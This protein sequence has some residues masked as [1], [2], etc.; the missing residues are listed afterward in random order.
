MALR[1]A[2]LYDLHGNLPALEAVLREVDREQ[3]DKIVVGGDIAAGPFPRETV[4]L[5]RS[6]G[7]LCIRGNADWREGEWGAHQW[8]WDQ[9]DAE[10]ADWLRTLPGHAVLDGIF[11][12]HATPHS[13]IEIVTSATTHDRL[14]EVLAGVR[15]NVVVAGHTHMQQD[16]RARRWRFVNPGSVGRPYEDQP[17]AYWAIVGDEVELRRTAYDFEAAAAATRASGHPRAY[18][19]AEENVLRVPSREEAIAAF[20]G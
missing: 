7:A 5:V 13:D 15:E 18:E 17:G 8:V 19:L 11:F 20:G 6:L 14:A 9:L 1:V 3:V 16:R 2:A 12:C 10:A 4:E